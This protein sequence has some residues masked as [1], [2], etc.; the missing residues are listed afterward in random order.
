M[1]VAHLAA[2]AAA[3]AWLLPAALPPLRVRVFG[4]AGDGRDATGSGRDGT[5]SGR[6][7]TASGQDGTVPGQDGR[8]PVGTERS[9]VGTEQST[10]GDGWKWIGVA[11]ALHAL[12]LVLE[13]GALAR[14]DFGMSASLFM[15][16]AAGAGWPLTR[17]QR[18]AR[19]LLAALAGVAALGPVFFVSDRPPPSLSLLPHL[20]PGT[21]AY[22][23][24][25][26]A[27]AQFA[28]L[29]AA[30]RRLKSG[31][32]EPGTPPILALE[33]ACFRSVA[34]AFWLL[35]LT[36]ATGAFQAGTTPEFKAL[37]HKNI[38]AALTWVV[39]LLLLLGRRK[40]GWRGRVARNWAAAGFGFLAL[41]YLGSGFVAQ[42]LLERS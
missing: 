19:V 28:G 8:D 12:S 15:L 33:A 39:F 32:P 40:F 26:V 3:A 9:P 4:R 24:A 38:F 35:T 36:L 16:A 37:T 25:L 1:I 42:V 7:A 10:V 6:D 18:E 34:A 27:L 22:A 5:D 21:L 30:E 17:G 29:G 20:V 31:I 14:L 13:W 41:S 23:F 2:V 11:F